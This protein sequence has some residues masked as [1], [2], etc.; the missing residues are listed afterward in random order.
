M[1]AARRQQG[2]CTMLQ[3]SKQQCLEFFVAQV[4]V[5]VNPTPPLPQRP[6]GSAASGLIAAPRNVAACRVTLTCSTKQL[7]ALL[8]GGL[9][10]D[11]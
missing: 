6:N 9:E 11:G 10:H 5:S 4:N 2:W 1:P 7:Q 3:P 8:L